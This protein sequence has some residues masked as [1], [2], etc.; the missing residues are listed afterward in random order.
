MNY[1][2]KNGNLRKNHLLNWSMTLNL[3]K[4]TQNPRKLHSKNCI[5]Q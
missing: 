2:L 4:D 5:D 1:I 3:K